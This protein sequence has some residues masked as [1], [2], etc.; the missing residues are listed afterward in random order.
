MTK[1]KKMN[2]VAQVLSIVVA[3]FI[4]LSVSSTAFAADIPLTDGGGWPGYTDYGYSDAGYTDYG[5]LNP[6]YTDYGYLDAGY[7][8]YGY[9]RD[10]FSMD[11]FSYS[12]ETPQGYFY[13]DTFSASPA[14]HAAP[15]AITPPSFQPPRYTP[16]QYQYPP[17]QPPR[18]APP[19]QQQQQQQQQANITNTNINTNTNTCTNWSCN[20][21]ITDN[22]INSSFNTAAVYPVTPQPIIQY[23]YPQP[24]YIPQPTYTPPAPY[25][26]LNQIPYTGLD[27]GI[28][29]N[30][31]YWMSLLA[32]AIAGAY[33]AIYYKGGAFALA[34][35]TVSSFRTPRVDYSMQ[36]SEPEAVETITPV[37]EESHEAIEEKSEINA[38][39]LPTAETHNTKDS[40]TLAHSADGTPRIV[41]NRG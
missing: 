41:I 17:Q 36:E 3:I 24:T 18:Y 2:V 40:M 20:T 34:S 11:T 29:G 39:S 10:T 32:F 27:F 1:S 25:V 26:S 12:Y 30:A 6:G 21:T 37:I 5:Y 15:M 28:L 8:D 33:L 31:I 35:S 7:T 14:F 4:V 23:Q 16:P 19:A 13:Q 38:F 9:G 22:S